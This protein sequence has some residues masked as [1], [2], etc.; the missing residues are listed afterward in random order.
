MV[1]LTLALEDGSTRPDHPERLAAR[2]AA[3]TWALRVLAPTVPAAAEPSGPGALKWI[4]KMG[5]AS[6]FCPEPGEKQTPQA[7]E[8]RRAALQQVRSQIEAEFATLQQ[9]GVT[10]RSA[11]EAQSSAPDLLRT[12]LQSLEEAAAA[13]GTRRREVLQVVVYRD[14]SEL[15]A[16]TCTPSW[17][18]GVFDGTLRLISGASEPVIRHET[19]HAQLAPFVRSAPL[20]FHEGLAQWFADRGQLQWTRPLTLMAHNQ[21]YIP[22]ASLNDS[23]LVLTGARDADL[24]YSQSA[25]MV[26]WLVSEHGASVV[27]EAVSYFAA[28]G[29]PNGLF[30]HLRPNGSLDEASFLQFLVSRAP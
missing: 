10:L 9:G 26:A 6:G 2:V 21:T 27:V 4:G 30:R 17:V 24:A 14:R 22:F 1:A 23:F 19:L 28:G 25:A 16:V 13:T 7:A 15:L 8:A 3:P 20:W 11:P 12:V 29:T 18:G 5:M